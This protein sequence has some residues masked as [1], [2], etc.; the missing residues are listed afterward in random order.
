[1]RP[2]PKAVPGTAFRPSQ[3]P[4]A[5]L[6]PGSRAAG[7]WHRFSAGEVLGGGEAEHERLCQ[8]A[9]VAAERDA[10]RVDARRIDAVEVLDPCARVDAQA[11]ER[12]R[13]SGGHVHGDA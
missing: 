11:A 10:T 1:S 4:R 13:D 5:R 9:R 3:A 12:V 6:V 8:A 2:E 7:A